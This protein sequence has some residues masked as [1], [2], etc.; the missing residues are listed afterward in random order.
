MCLFAGISLSFRW[1]FQ[2]LIYSFSDYKKVTSCK[3]QICQQKQIIHSFWF[4]KNEEKY[5]FTS[6]SFKPNVQCYLFIEVYFENR[7]WWTSSGVISLQGLLKNPSSL[8]RHPPGCWIWILPF[9]SHFTSPTFSSHWRVNGLKWVQADGVINSSFL[10]F[11]RYLS[12]IRN[13]RFTLH[14]L[15]H[16]SCRQWKQ[17][18]RSSKSKLC[19]KLLPKF[20]N[21]TATLGNVKE[22][23][24]V[25]FIVLV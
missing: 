11:Q 5:S 15:G 3:K 16:Q 13:I 22:W 10:F 2:N 18:S 9:S 8:V 4:D 24:K 1:P 23:P 12:R 21:N 20:A 6:G 25:T 17:D 14:K 7:M 19:L